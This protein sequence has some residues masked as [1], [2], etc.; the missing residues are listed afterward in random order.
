LLEIIHYYKAEKL[1]KMQIVV[2]FRKTSVLSFEQAP[3][4]AQLRESVAVEE[5]VPAECFFLQRDG[6]VLRDQDVLSTHSL[7]HSQIP[8]SEMVVVRASMRLSGGKGGFGA[9][10]KSMAKQAGSK[11]T[12]DFGACRDL[13]GRRL[14]HVNDEL[15]LKKWQVR[16]PLPLTRLLAY[17]LTHLL[18]TEQTHDHTCMYTRLMHLRLLFTGSEGPRR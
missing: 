14:R 3:S 1:E 9:M 6:Q 11:K 8:S 12:T 15:I 16:L 13:S 10:L 4:G 18:S 5:G 2:H 17:S 7:T